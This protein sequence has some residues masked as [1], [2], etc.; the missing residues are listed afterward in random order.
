MTTGS[1]PENLKPFGPYHQKLGGKN[2]QNDKN[3]SKIMFIRC[4]SCVHKNNQMALVP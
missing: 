3:L 2:C 1:F 4:L